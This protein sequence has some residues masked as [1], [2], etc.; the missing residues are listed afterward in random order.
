MEDSF[1]K[2]F[3]DGP[4]P[5]PVDRI[6][7]FLEYYDSKVLNVCIS[8]TD[9]FFT[10][11]DG[12]H[13]HDT[14]E[15]ILPS[16]PMPFT[17]VDDRCVSLNA[18]NI[19]SLNPGQIHGPLGKMH[20]KT[21]M[22][23][24]VDKQFLND[25]AFQLFSIKEFEFKNEPL[26]YNEEVKKIMLQFLDE[27]RF[28]QVG[29]QFIL[30]C[31]ST[32]LVV[33]IL[34]LERD[35]SYEELAFKSSVRDNIYKV[36]QFLNENYNSNDYSTKEIAAIAN[37]SCYHF[38]RAFKNEIG[39]T[40]YE[41]LIDIKLEKAKQMLRN[42]NYSLTDI[43]YSC[44]FSNQSQFSTMFKKRLGMSPSKYRSM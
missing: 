24:H 15:F 43:C 8:K 19:L 12:Y 22:A 3:G 28:H 25:I 39:K 1:K 31:L 42:K 33:N 10:G 40:P 30:E 18:N 20:I 21:L 6:D 29:H 13:S 14:Y 27:A 17:R 44:G 11:N 38:I 4:F 7:E 41:Y 32:Q 34:R 35:C 26:V 5:F 9:T 36:I 37:L 16:D 23:T 2:R